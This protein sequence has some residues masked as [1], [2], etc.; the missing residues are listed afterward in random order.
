METIDLAPAHFVDYG[1]LER[2]DTYGVEVDQTLWRVKQG[3]AFA[4]F[5]AMPD[6]AFELISIANRQPGLPIGVTYV[7]GALSRFGRGLGGWLTGERPAGWRVQLVPWSGMLAGAIIGAT[8][9]RRLGLDGLWLS[10][11]LALVLG[12][13]FMKVPRRWQMTYT[14]R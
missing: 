9:E 5:E 10:G 7:T 13:A 11:A 2:A 1:G 8:L 12:I 6:Q 14:S 4:D 3:T